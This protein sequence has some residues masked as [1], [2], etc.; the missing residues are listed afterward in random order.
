MVQIGSWLH[1]FQERNDILQV[2]STEDIRAAK[3]S[4]KTG[5]FLSF[6]NASPI[7]NELDRLGIFHALGVR[8]IQLDD[9]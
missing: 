4:G 5:I 1:R 3:E 8:V 9:K 6:R 7:E 2:K